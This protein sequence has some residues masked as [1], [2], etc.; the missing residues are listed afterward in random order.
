MIVNNLLFHTHTKTVKAIVINTIK[1]E[2]IYE[3]N[4]HY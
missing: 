4:L 2:K 1:G 3:K